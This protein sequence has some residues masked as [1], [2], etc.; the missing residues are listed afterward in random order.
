MRE[1]NCRVEE[2]LEKI[3]VKVNQIALDAELHQTTIDKLINNIQSLIEH[4]LWPVTGQIKPELLQSPKGLQSILT[5]ME[6]LQLSLRDD[7]KIRR[8]RAESP[9]PIAEKSTASKEK[10]TKASSST[11]QS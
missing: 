9:L 6:N 7:Y 1:S 8:K 10:N 5:K 2:K 3:D 11:K 4:I